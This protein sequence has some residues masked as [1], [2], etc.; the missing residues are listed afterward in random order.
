VS[1]FDRGRLAGLFGCCL[2]GALAGWAAAIAVTHPE[3]WSGARPD[4]ALVVYGA[5]AWFGSGYLVGSTARGRAPRRS[6]LRVAG[7]IAG[8]AFAAK[9]LAPALA[10]WTAVLIAAASFGVLV[11]TLQTRQG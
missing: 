3:V 9:A 11:G 1:R 2:W 8:V 6:D 4:A 7:L 5:A 10:A